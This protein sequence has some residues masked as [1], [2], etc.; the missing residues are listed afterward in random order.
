MI[1]DLTNLR[2]IRSN[3]PLDDLELRARYPPVDVMGKVI[4]TVHPHGL[5]GAKGE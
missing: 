3:I 2:Y 5:A 1:I 4:R